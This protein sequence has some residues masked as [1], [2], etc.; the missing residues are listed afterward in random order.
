LVFD[1]IAIT[2]AARFDYPSDFDAEWS[3]KVS[4]AL[5]KNGVFRYSVTAHLARSYRAPT[6]NDLYW[7]RDSYAEGNPNLSPERGVN[8]DIGISGAYPIFGEVSVTAN[9][10][11]NLIDSLILW[12]P[13][14]GGLW[15]PMNISKTDARGIETTVRWKPFK[16]YLEFAADYTFMRALD[17]SDS[18]TTRDKD[19]IYRP[20]NKVDATVTGRYEKAEINFVVHYVGKRYINA[21]NT[22]KLDAYKMI[23]ANISYSTVLSD[24]NLMGKFEMMNLSD[25]NIMITDGSP[26]PGRAMRLT[27]GCSF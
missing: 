13:G 1:D 15:R 16:E 20:R 5:Q 4:I 17:K 9:Y 26:I 2:P 24:I 21:A 10:F 12:A 25:E 23:D 19:L 7:P 11:V 3:P 27:V 18:P 8:Y 6:F 22:K 14:A